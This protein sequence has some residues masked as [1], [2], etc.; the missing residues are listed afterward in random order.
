MNEFDKI[1]KIFDFLT[2]HLEDL[3]EDSSSGYG[4]NM[5]DYDLYARDYLEFAENQ[6]IEGTP[7]AL[8]NCI[9]NLKRA[10]D[11][12]TDTFLYTLSLFDT[13]RRRNLKFEKKLEL[14]SSIGVFNSTSLAKLNKIRNKMEHEYALPQIDEID[15][16]FD[17]VSAFVSNLESVIT[18]LQWDE[19][20]L[21]ARDN[22]DG[23][24][25]NFRLRLDRSLEPK[26][27]ATWSLP[28]SNED[29]IE[30]TFNE[31]KGFAFYLRCLYMLNIKKAFASNSYVKR[32]IEKAF[33]KLQIDLEENSGRR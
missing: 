32:N 31:Y 12:Q 10:V 3:E 9:S 17:L 23:F 24:D 21:Y 13:F 30:I 26:M 20:N 11:C 33:N 4:F 8:I 27:I 18:V 16:Y 19:I 2:Q 14:I 22:E 1:K 29:I 5:P 28:H 7:E 15:L 25:T 6:L